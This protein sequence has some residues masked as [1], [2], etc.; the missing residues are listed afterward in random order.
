[1]RL[2]LCGDVMTGRGI[3]QILPHP[4]DPTL[5]ESWMT[6]AEDYVALAERAS[7]PI[8]RRVAPDYIWG[9]ALPALAARAPDLRIIN[10]ETAVTA[11]GE[12]EPKGINYRMHPDNIA[13][14]TA[15]GV[16][17]CVLANNHVGDW[18]P[19]GLRDTLAA[20]EGAG[21]AAVG[22]GRD[23]AEAA[24]P[25]VLE[26][27]SARLL[28]FAYGLPPSGVPAGWA[29]G[30]DR[31]GVSFLPDAGEDA[32]RRVAG[33]I[34][35][36]AAP[37][38]AVV[39]SLHWGSNWGY[40]I[41]PVHRR[42]ARALLE[43]GGAHVLHGHS[44]H[45]PLGIEVIAGRPALY[46]CGDFIND[47]EGISG[48]EE[49]RP[50]LVLGYVLDLDPRDHALQ[51]MEM[52]PFRLRRFRL[53]RPEEVELDWL[54]GRMTRECARFGHSAERTEAGTLRLVW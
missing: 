11:G 18:G 54:A 28:L 6:S 37:E 46:G 2:F 22:A 52:L 35:R 43:E 7:G 42:F 17:A 53:T 19:A 4:A 27:S 14:L 38:D 48:H 13:C 51:A 8:P 44:S 50:E 5:Y 9:E 20:L 3:D 33:D 47:Y 39:V 12:P 24:R 25:A 23:A 16:D 41:P 15:A 10:L 49:K 29:A 34:A 45:H 26:T 1:M 30:P 36:H 21:L 40:E 31:A 32:L